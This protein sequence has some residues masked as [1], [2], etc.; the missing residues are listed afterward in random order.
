L[1]YILCPNCK[2]KT[3]TGYILCKHC[4]K[5]L[6]GAETPSLTL[7]AS[8]QSQDQFF[9]K[10]GLVPDEKKP[11]AYILTQGATRIGRLMDNDIVIFDELASRHHAVI[12]RDAEGHYLA[13]DLHSTNGTSLNGE[14]LTSPVSIKSGDELRIGRTTIRFE[15]ST[16]LDPSLASTPLR[17]DETLISPSISPLVEKASS[18]EMADTL[19]GG[20]ISLGNFRPLARP[21]WALKHIKDEH[22]LDTYT[23]KG[24]DLPGYIRL[25]ERDVFLWELMDGEH[26]L[27]DI[28]VAFFQ[29][30]QAIGTDRLL[31]LLEELTQKDFLQNTQPDQAPPASGFK[32]KVMAF[33][34]RLMG[35]FFQA[36]ISLQGA[37]EW[38][39]SLYQRFGWR[40]FTRTGQIIMALIAVAGFSTFIFI[41]LQGGQSLFKVADSLALGLV[42]IAVAN[43]FTIFLHEMGHALTVKSYNRQVRRVGFMIYFGMP[44]FFV[45]TS[46]IW[47][48]PKG[49]RI[50]ASIAGPTVDFLAGSIAS[51]GMIA[52]SSPV[53]TDLLFI[54]AAW[55]YIDTF[56]NLNPLLEL[57]GYFILMDWL[58]IPLL[59]KQSLEFIRR[60]LLTKLRRREHFSSRERI[61]TMFGILSAVWSVIAVGI[62]FLYEGPWLLSVFQGNL[63]AAVSLMV[64]AAGGLVIGLLALRFRKRKQTSEDGSAGG[65]SDGT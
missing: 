32:S 47:M 63:Q 59:R 64:M 3:P 58:E 25:S 48:E 31:D 16:V 26:S 22:G 45:D 30:Y 20:K 35:G 51:L 43:T 39:T 5:P 65:A 54:L 28:L 40:F 1:A 21:G 9:C 19:W 13:E 38:I 46:D 12:S 62:F 36:Q 2:Y 60:P 18:K 37:D 52:S 41:L 11:G 53:L 49:P 17:P 10:P 42:V 29:R 27:R 56:F 8:I 55:S 15:E 23:L 14:R 44:T 34:R 50:Q 24:L 4:G 7:N 57:D 61:F 33:G 6:P